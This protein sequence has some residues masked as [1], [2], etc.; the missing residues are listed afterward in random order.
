MTE[1]YKQWEY[2]VQTIG[3]V[4]G[5]KDE[6]IQ[7][8]LDE[9]GAEGWE[10]INVFTPENSGKITMVAKRPLTER[11]RRMRSMPLQP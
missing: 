7:A 2:R 3:S 6:L 1:E 5:T 4:F 8:T 11:V 10:A 9:W